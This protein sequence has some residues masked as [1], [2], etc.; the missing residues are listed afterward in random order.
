M[1]WRKTDP[2]KTKNLKFSQLLEILSVWKHLRAIYF[3]KSFKW[4]IAMWEFKHMHI[5]FSIIYF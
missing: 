3:N 1:H 2:L 4:N 5:V